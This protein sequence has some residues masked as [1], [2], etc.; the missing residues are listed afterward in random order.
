[1]T[2][3]MIPG[4]NRNCPVGS[5]SWQNKEPEGHSELQFEAH[6]GELNHRGD[7]VKMCKQLKDDFFHR[8]PTTLQGATT[9]EQINITALISNQHGVTP[10]THMDSSRPLVP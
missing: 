6:A 10:D 7:T 4:V 1:M 3:A 2:Q 9:P 5:E 8:T